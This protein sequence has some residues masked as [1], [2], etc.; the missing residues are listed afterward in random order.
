MASMG[1]LGSFDSKFAASVLAAFAVLIFFGAAF[2]SFSC[3]W[4]CPFGLIQD[5]LAKV[6]VKKFPLPSWSGHLRLP[7]FIGLVIAVPYLTRQM[8][9]CDVCPAGTL[10]RLWQQA[11]N[12]PLFFKIPQGGWAIFSIALFIALLLA[13][14]FIQRPFCSLFC[15]IGGLH[16]ILNKVS[17]LFINVDKEKCVNCGRCADACPH[18]IDPVTD[19]AHSQCS[20]CL[21]C[22]SVQC[23]FISADLRL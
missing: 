14:L 6:P 23:K 18:G 15:P 19:P 9:F 16:G 11:M 20:R 2:G 5:L 1:M 10:N 13:A 21:E 12:I 22:V 4:L 3:G 7:I 17:G 8:F